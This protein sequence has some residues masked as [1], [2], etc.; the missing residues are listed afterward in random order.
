MV[1]KYSTL[2]DIL[3][4]GI[5]RGDRGIGEMAVRMNL[6]I[7]AGLRTVDQLQQLDSLRLAVQIYIW[8]TRAKQGSRGRA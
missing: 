6:A 4:R 7:E 5:V 8:I 3:D 1:K 2:L